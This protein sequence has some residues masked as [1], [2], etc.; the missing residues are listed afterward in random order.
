MPTHSVSASTEDLLAAAAESGAQSFE[1]GRFIITYKEDAF[2]S[3]LESLKAQNLRVADVRDAEDQVMSLES[4]GDADVVVFPEI[5]AA[6]VSGEAFADRGLGAESFMAADSTIATIEPEY[7]V[8]AL[9][10]PGEYL[11]GFLRATETI[12]NDLG[13]MGRGEP[14]DSGEV[15]PMVLGATWGLAASR[16]PPCTRSGRSISVAVLDTGVDL[17]HPDFIGRG[18]V[19]ATFV[20]QPV[21]DLHG[22]GTHCIGT[23]CGPKAPFG[24]TPRYG[25]GFEVKILAGKVL[26]N[27]GSGT[28]G[29]ILSGINWAIA[30]KATIISMSLGR[31]GATVEAGYTAAGAAALRRGIL[32]VAAAG[33]RSE[34]TGAPANSP[35]IMSVASLNQALKPSSF[36]NHG[37]VEIAAAGENVF[38]TVPMPLRYGVKSGTSMATP[39]VAGCAALWAQTS[40]ALRGTTLWRQLV[41]SAKPLP[42]PASRV[43]AGLVQ[44]PR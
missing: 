37:K 24:T 27:S 28:T 10:D 12:A 44:A 13:Q 14:T 21:Q 5:G 25:C 23:S 20:G 40:A 6:L 17:K 31:P 38:S 8:F 4:T 16:I 7:F 42:Y 30:S 41:A 29:G 33:N 2:E 39:H 32:I 15:E 34:P 36:S 43:G 11:R 18:I 35:T 22:H 19:S 26:T 3:G 1:T 9:G